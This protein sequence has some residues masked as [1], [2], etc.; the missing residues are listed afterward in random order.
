MTL[1]D[2]MTDQQPEALRLAD[3]L[4]G[5]WTQVWHMVASAKELR[6]QHTEIERLRA[7]VDGLRKYCDRYQWLIKQAWFQQAFDRFD[8]D[9]GGM[10]SRFESEC[11]RIID[12]VLQPTKEHP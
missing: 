12:A 3:A 10:Q 5:E 9:D 1:G 4:D 7:E 6:R 11:A 2:E 8:P